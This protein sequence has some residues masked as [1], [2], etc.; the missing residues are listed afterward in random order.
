MLRIRRRNRRHDR[1]RRLRLFLDQPP[2]RFAHLPNAEERRQV[3]LGRRAATWLVIFATKGLRKAVHAPRIAYADDATSSIDHRATTVGVPQVRVALDAQALPAAQRGDHAARNDRFGPERAANGEHCLPEIDF[4]VRRA[5]RWL[6]LLTLEV[7][8]QQ[9][10]VAGAVLLEHL[11]LER[12]AADTNLQVAVADTGMCIRD[13][14][15]A[16]GQH[17]AGTK[18]L[19]ALHATWVLCAAFWPTILLAANPNDRRRHLR[20]GCRETMRHA[21]RRLLQ[22]LVAGVGER[23]PQRGANTTSRYNHAEAR[24]LHVLELGIAHFAPDMFRAVDPKEAAVGPEDSTTFAACIVARV[25]QEHLVVGERF[26]AESDLRQRVA[27][28]T[29]ERQHVFALG[30]RDHQHRLADVGTNAA[31]RCSL[32]AIRRRGNTQQHQP[33]CGIVGHDLGIELGV[34]GVV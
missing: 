2:E 26:A 10:Q 21:R 17:N 32:Q 22:T 9:R 24:L 28:D 15:A 33:R 19:M 4:A 6:Q 1:L 12:L 5:L 25:G 31:K 3:R 8:L 27:G 23:L 14:Q 11:R 20:D 7:D 13:H 34:G 18:M 30:S 29:N 16:L